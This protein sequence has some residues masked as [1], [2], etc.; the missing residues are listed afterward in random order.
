M[1]CIISC[2]T[3]EQNV[4]KNTDACDPYRLLVCVVT[5]LPSHSLWLF[6]QE[7]CMSLAFNPWFY[8]VSAFTGSCFCD[9]FISLE[10]DHPLHL[11]FTHDIYIYHTHTVP[12]RRSNLKSAYICAIFI[13]IYIKAQLLVKAIDADHFMLQPQRNCAHKP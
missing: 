5:H 2:V 13:Y 6:T 1:V 12:S 10:C 4:R 7:I 3:Y 8:M 9:V 11:F